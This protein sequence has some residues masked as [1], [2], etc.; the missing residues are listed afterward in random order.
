M[1]AAGYGGHRRRSGALHVGFYAQDGVWP[2]S[3]ET[4][5][6]VRRAAAALEDAGAAVEEV[7][8]PPL[9]EAEDIFFRMM[10]ADGGA[11]AR[12][13]LAPAGGRHIEQMLFV[14]EM[15]KDFAVD[16]SGFFEQL[17]RWASLRSRMRQ[18][19]GAHDVV[20]S[21][22]TPGPAPLHGC[23]PGDEPLESSSLVE[24]DGVL[25][26]GRSRLGGPGG[27]AA[28]HADRRPPRRRAFADHVALAAGAVEAALGGYAGAGAPLHAGAA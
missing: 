4:E 12:A 9:A 21:P 6:A 11:R 13:D 7:V 23:Q 18:F 5:E 2:A 16:A 22:V 3:P 15:T 19:V 24:R 14:L 10:A 17:G 1:S 28:W 27:V 20:L 8:P 26:R 25:G